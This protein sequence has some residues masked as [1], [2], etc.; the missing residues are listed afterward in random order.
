ME[1]QDL[2]FLLQL[3]LLLAEL[4]LKQVHHL[5]LLILHYLHLSSRIFLRQD[6]Q[7][8][9]VLMILTTSRLVLLFPQV[10]PFLQNGV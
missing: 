5:L 9:I 6:L 7:A 4:F 8:C 1:L 3:H 2:L 10:F